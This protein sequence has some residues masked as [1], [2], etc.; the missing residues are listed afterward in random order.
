MHGQHPVERLWCSLKD[1]AVHL[2]G[3]ADGLTAR[4]LI[5]DWVAFLQRRET[6]HDAERANPGRGIPRPD[7]CGDVGKAQQPQEDR[8]KGTL[9]TSTS[10]G[11]DLSSAARLSEMVG[12][13]PPSAATRPSTVSSPSRLPEYLALYPRAGRFA[14]LRQRLVTQL[15][16]I[17][18]R[19]AYFQW[20]RISDSPNS[21]LYQ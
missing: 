9:A 6:A 14:V 13:P 3:I 21:Y 16:N 10:T 2:H 4:R 7:A 17:K 18:N 20:V 19:I 8:S 11:I 12:P 1:E 5:R 15:H